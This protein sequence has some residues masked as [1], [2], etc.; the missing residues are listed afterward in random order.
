MKCSVVPSGKLRGSDWFLFLL[1]L[2]GNSPVGETIRLMNMMFLFEKTMMPSLMEKGIEKN[3]LPR[4][5]ASPTGAFSNDILEAIDFFQGIGFL[6]M[7][8]D[9][10]G[11]DYSLTSLGE[12]YVAEHICPLLDTE[13]TEQLSVFKEK[14]LQTSVASLQNY[15][16]TRYP[17]MLKS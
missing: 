8:G 13:T 4:F 16:A 17:E 12:R 11:T 14:I 7:Q 2:D 6:K 1:S 3:D 9:E 5:K 10:K 15:I